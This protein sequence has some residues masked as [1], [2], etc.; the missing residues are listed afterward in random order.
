MV[1]NDVQKQDGPLAVEP[2]AVGTVEW[3]QRGLLSVLVEVLQA[4]ADAVANSGFEGPK[5]A[6]R[7]YKCRSKAV[8][9]VDM[10]ATVVPALQPTAPGIETRP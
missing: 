3:L 5:A 9:L 4:V 7:P 8:S 1:C 10:L 6:T 2:K